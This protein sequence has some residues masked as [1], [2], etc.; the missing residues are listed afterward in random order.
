MAQKL[1]RLC[2][3]Q[4]FCTAA[5]YAQPRGRALI[6]RRRLIRDSLPQRCIDSA[7]RTTQR[8]AP[9]QNRRR[10]RDKILHGRGGDTKGGT[11]ET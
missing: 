7:E 3:V 6:R 2:A 4:M 9:S 1:R 5:R 11:G 10:E 8:L